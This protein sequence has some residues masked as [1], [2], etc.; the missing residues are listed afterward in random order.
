MLTCRSLKSSG[1]TSASSDCL[2]YLRQQSES[3][4]NKAC[5]RW[6]ASTSSR[7]MAHSAGND[8]WSEFYT[9]LFIHTS[10][11]ASLPSVGTFQNSHFMGE[12]KRRYWGYRLAMGNSPKN[13][14]PAQNC[15][16]LTII[17]SGTNVTNSQACISSISEI[18]VRFGS[19]HS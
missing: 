10:W 8:S 15:P 2:L 19:R 6:V 3:A 7:A 18:V 5:L 16:A 14:N 11:G 4:S 1:L 9:G 17:E 12:A 13:I